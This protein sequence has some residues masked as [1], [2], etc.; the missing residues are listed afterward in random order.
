MKLPRT[1]ALTFVLA[2]LSSTGPLSLDMYLPSLPDIGRSLEASTLQ[3]QLT[4][5]S[6]LFGSAVGQIFYGPISDRFGRRPLL[7]AALLLYAL[8]TVGCAAAQSIGA[9]VALRFVQAI[10]VAGV[11]VLARAMV[12]DIYSGAHAG[13]ELSQMGAI[14][15]FV[16]V[17]APVIGGALQIWFGWRASFVLLLL[18]AGVMGSIVAARLPETLRHRTKTPF[19]LREMS[20][21]YRSVAAHQGF[22]A[23]L[24][25]LTVG[26]AG[27][28]AWLSGAS[29][30][31]Q[32]AIYG[33]SPFAFGAT[34]AT[35]SVGYILATLVAARTVIRFGLDRTVGIGTAGMALGGLMMAAVVGLASPHVSWFVG[36]MMLYFAGLGFAVPASRA[37]ALTPFRD[38]AATAAAVMGFTQQMG[39]AIAATVVGFYLGHSAWPVASVVAVMGCMSFL[40]WLATR[41]VRVAR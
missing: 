34:L 26:L 41:K 4:I 19:S 15:G 21:L 40:I 9:L 1:F 20:A 27:L 39:A 8:A 35:G 12:R 23:N 14:T 13:R 2:L 30:V 25:I 11:M 16:P 33:L 3:V 24:A 37:G 6:Y 10:G 31:M 7:L 22:L 5:S 29:I 38:R 36:A 32:S 17:I 28:F 18:F